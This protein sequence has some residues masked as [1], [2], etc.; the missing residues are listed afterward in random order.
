M[1]SRLVD[2]YTP[3]SANPET[4]KEVAEMPGMGQAILEKG[5]EKGI[6][7]GLADAANL[8]NYLWS[9]GRG[10]EAK[11]AAGDKNL[12]DQLLAEFKQRTPQT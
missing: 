6:G 10:E 9:N 3:A 7:I 2:R 12:L 4:V 1:K 8:M 11:R 5:I